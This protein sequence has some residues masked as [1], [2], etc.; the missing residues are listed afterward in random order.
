MDNVPFIDD[1]PIKP[2]DFRYRGPILIALVD[3][4]F[5]LNFPSLVDGEILTFH[6]I[7]M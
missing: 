1:S 4:E 2:G 5:P 3:G 7:T 6:Q